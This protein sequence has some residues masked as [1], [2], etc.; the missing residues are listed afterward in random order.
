MPERVWFD[1]AVFRVTP[2]VE[3]EEF[4]NAG[5]V[6]FC[7]E[8]N[9]LGARVHLDRGLLAAMAPGCDPELVA[10]HLAALVRVAEGGGEGGPIGGLSR[11]ERFYW[12]TAPRSTVVQVSPVHAG[13]AE[14]PEPALERLFAA[15]VARG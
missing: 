11:R 8:R 1:Y 4:F 5:I 7:A 2:R 13:A 9:W 10:D 12:L 14:S 3:R 6:L 15:L